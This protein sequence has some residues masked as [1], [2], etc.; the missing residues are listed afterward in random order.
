MINVLLIKDGILRQIY[1]DYPRTSKAFQNT[2]LTSGYY[3]YFNCG[4]ESRN[5]NAIP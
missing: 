5:R 3:S 4:Y 1:A 2:H